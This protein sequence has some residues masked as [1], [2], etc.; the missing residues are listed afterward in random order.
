MGGIA[1]I[2]IVGGGVIGLTTAWHLA[3]DG[4]RVT[5]VDQGEV[6]RQASWAGAGILPDADPD[7]ARTPLELL[8]AHSI[9]MWPELSA[10]L[11]QE[12]GLDNGYCV[13][14]GIEVPED[15]GTVPTEEWHGEGTPAEPVPEGV[16]YP[17]LAQVRN[18]RHMQALAAACRGRGVALEEGWPVRRLVTEGDQIVGVEGERGYCGAGQVLIANGAWA[19]QL[20]VELPVRPVRGQIVLFDAGRPTPQTVWMLGKRY[21]VLRGDGMVLAGSTEEEA[22]FDATPTEEAVAGLVAFARRLLPWLADAPVT[23][24]WAGLRPA[25]PDGLPYLGAVHGVRGLHVAAGH[26]RAGLG[27]SPA[28]GVVMAQHLTGRETLLPLE[29]FRMDRASS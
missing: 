10:Q 1:D 11:Q 15:G 3:G 9:R 17:R 2:L 6:G 26:F 25:S 4:V 23:R 7:R 13:C 8:K 22:G 28:T 27:L 5:V 18:P 16:F 20:G 19:G 24:S 14:G 29:A 12:T 21:V